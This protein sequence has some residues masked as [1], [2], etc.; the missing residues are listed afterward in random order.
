ME[1]NIMRSKILLSCILLV[2]LST[3]LYG[4]GDKVMDAA[5]STAESVAQMLS[6]NVTGQTGKSYATQWFNFTVKSIEE[7]SEYGGYVPQDGYTF[8]DVV[9]EETGTFEEASPMGT[10]DF[11][12]DAPTF[13][14]YIYPLDPESDEM[15][16]LEFYLE[17]KQ[18]VEYHMVYEIPVNTAELKLMYTEIDIEEN[19][20]VT[21]NIPVQ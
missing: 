20:G 5:R 18:T 17:P 3:S 15:M 10:Y 9:I 6:G 7:V 21:F 12:M 2:V 11:Y 16:P 4:C 14:D 8:F 1:E 13:E 19:E